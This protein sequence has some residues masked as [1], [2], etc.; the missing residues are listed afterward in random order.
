MPDEAAR[1]DGRVMDTRRDSADFRDRIYQPALVALEER[2]KLFIGSGE[3]VYEGMVIGENARSGDL[4]VNPLK[5]K[6]LTNIRASGKDDAVVLTPP[7]RM[8]LEQAIA[9]LADDELLEVT[10]HHLRLRK[11]IL[12][13]HERKRE[14]RNAN[15]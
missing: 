9:Y 2:G 15:A 3:D 8:T 1:L 5:G 14:L 10:P 13:P 12:D 11:R 4:I 7:T 6:K